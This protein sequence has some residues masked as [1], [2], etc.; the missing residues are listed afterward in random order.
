MSRT[1]GF[2]GG[3]NKELVVLWRFHIFE[4]RNHI[5]KLVL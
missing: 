1:G 4:N 2:R 3:T 5:P